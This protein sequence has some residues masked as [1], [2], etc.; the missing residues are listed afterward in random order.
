[1]AFCALRIHLLVCLNVCM[2]SKFIPQVSLARNDFS[3]QN[4]FGYT[5]KKLT[6]LKK[7]PMRS[8]TVNTRYST[9]THIYTHTY[10]YHMYSVYVHTL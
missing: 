7:I 8:N 10:I 6:S 9:H 3:Y 1:M 4:L 5:C 2:I